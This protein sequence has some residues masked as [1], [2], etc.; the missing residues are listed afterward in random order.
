MSSRLTAFWESFQNKDFSTAQEKF[1]AL[2]SNN[3]QAVLAELFQKS[4]Y[5]RTPAMVSVLRRRLHDN[6]SFKDFYQAWFPSEDM[7]NKVEMAGQVY[8]QH[9]ETP[10]RVINAINSNDPNEI[11]SVGI[12][13]VANKEEEQGLW[14]Y[15][16]NATM[17]EDKNNELRHDRIEE[18]AE[19]ELLGIFHVET[20]DNLGAPF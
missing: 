18:V 8:Q 17:G 7:C 2:E 5:H 4:E 11:I 13:W 14:E 3:K 1:D 10:V 12:T 19:G 20:D 9:F 6:Q 16:K 15:I